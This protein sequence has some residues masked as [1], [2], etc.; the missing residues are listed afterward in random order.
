MINIADP[1]WETFSKAWGDADAAR[2]FAAGG[3]P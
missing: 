1:E 2:V 3:M